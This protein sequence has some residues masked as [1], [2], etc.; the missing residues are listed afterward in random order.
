MNAYKN[1]QRGD[2]PL[3]KDEIGG[4]GEIQSFVKS[5]MKDM[6]FPGFPGGFFTRGIPNLEP[7]MKF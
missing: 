6:N 4:A 2:I 7:C 5:K 3:Q 1:C